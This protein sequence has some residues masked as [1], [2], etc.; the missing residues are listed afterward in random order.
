MNDH[1]DFLKPHF[2]IGSKDHIVIDGTKY[3][4]VSKKHRSYV[5]QNDNGLCETF[6]WGRLGKLSAA[7]KIEHFPNHWSAAQAKKRASVDVLGLYE[8]KPSQLR[9]IKTRQ[10]FVE[11]IEQMVREEELRVND[12]S[13]AKNKY[14]IAARASELYRD[15]QL[16]EKELFQQADKRV[17]RKRAENGG[18]KEVILRM[19][20]PRTLRRWCKQFESDGLIGLADANWKKGNRNNSFSPSENVLLNKTIR[21]SYLGEL[22]STKAGTY[23]DV[24]E[25]FSDANKLRAA[26]GETLLRVPSRETVRTRINQLDA[27]EVV[28]C[29]EG[30]AAAQKRFTPVNAGLE[31]SRPLERVEMDEWC[32]DL[33]S[34][35]K[36]TGFFSTFS[37]EELVALGIDG[38]KHRWWVS[39]AIDCRTK[40]VLGLNLVNDPSHFS[41]V[42]TLD[43]VTSDKEPWADAVGSMT[44]WHMYGTPETV[45]TDNGSAYCSEAFSEAC[46][47]LSITHLRTIAGLPMMRGTVE[48]FF[49]TATTNLLQRLNG[50]TFSN[51]LEKGDYNSEAKACLEIRDLCFALVRWVVDD[52]HNTNHGGLGGR[53]PLEQWEADMKEGNVPLRSAPSTSQKRLAFGLR[54]TRVVSKSGVS[55]LGVHYNADTLAHEFMRKDKHEV[56]VRWSANDIGRVSV[57]LEDNWVEVPAVNKCFDGVHAQD[58]LQA[59]RNLAARDPKQEL[60]REEVV[61][62]SIK[63]ITSLNYAKSIE[64]GVLTQKWTSERI[65]D[66]EETLLN[67]IR[68]IEAEMPSDAL[69]QADYGKDIVPLPE[70]NLGTGD[71]GLLQPKRT[72]TMQFPTDEES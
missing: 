24:K 39:A 18:S 14:E 54:E 15:L 60:W 23:D 51:V 28:L 38:K 69:Q 8:L 27:F 3:K 71:D 50:R 70:T 63:D 66:Q 20:H 21:D 61:S 1:T 42:H 72:A 40:C 30:M 52:Y 29:R 44:V 43:M 32:I 53:T 2:H 34:I 16:G 45:V 55:V 35:F 67:G 49:R 56:Q 22:K 26:D 7:G 9:S 47:D 11:T 41:S 58:W 33:I 48:R 4:F 25:A 13:L 31:V 64:R 37:E 5:L 62:R 6:D 12:D 59:R 46:A 17:N 65:K 10:A 36:E 57:R 68:V 19:P